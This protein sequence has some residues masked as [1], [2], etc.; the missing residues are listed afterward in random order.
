MKSDVVWV[1]ML[2]SMVQSYQR[3]RIQGCW[4]VLSPTYFP[5]YFVWWL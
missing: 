2:Y 5:M 1:I 3:F 4:Y